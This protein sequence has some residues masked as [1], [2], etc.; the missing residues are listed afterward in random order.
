VG[1]SLTNLE[2]AAGCGKRKKKR[3]RKRKKERRAA[4]RKRGYFRRSYFNNMRVERDGTSG[5]RLF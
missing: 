2:E 3:I 4:A 5:R 1:S